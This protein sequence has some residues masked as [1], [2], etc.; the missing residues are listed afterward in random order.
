MTLAALSP[1][2]LLAISDLLIGSRIESALEALG[3]RVTYLTLDNG[4]QRRPQSEPD[5]RSAESLTGPGAKLM[6]S[7]TQAA[8]ALFIVDLANEDFA[9]RQWLPL[10]RTAPA[11]RRTPVLCFAPHVEKDSIR[12]ARELNVNAVVSRGKL[13]RGLAELVG[14]HARFDPAYSAHPSFSAPLPPIALSGLRV[15]N[16][17]DYF[18]AHEQLEQAWKEAEAPLKHLLLG[19]TQVAVARHHLDNGNFTGS[20]KMILRSRQW[21]QNLPDRCNKV[22]V[23]SLRRDLL[24]MKEI[25]VEN[26]IAAAGVSKAVPPLSIDFVE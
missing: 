23:A 16:Q 7:F 21:L 3:Y 13:V 9:W 18:A 8:P 24:D 17:G 10:L 11:T 6:D 4:D 22:A 26:R 1:T 19:L 14:E 20:V 2:V 25:V 5:V 15:F 12:D